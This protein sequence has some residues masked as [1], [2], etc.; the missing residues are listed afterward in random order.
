MSL[1]LDTAGDGVF[2]T[3]F[4]DLDVVEVTLKD[5][6]GVLDV[7]AGDL[8]LNE[9]RGGDLKCVFRFRAGWRLELDPVDLIPWD[10]ETE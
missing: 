5:S 2:D 9:W 1:A 10:L 6:R 7:A 4:L 8:T 3:N